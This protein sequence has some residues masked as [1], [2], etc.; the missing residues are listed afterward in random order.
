MSETASFRLEH[1]T[2]IRQEPARV[3][4]LIL[5]VDRWPEIFPSCVA[6]SVLEQ[7]ER[8]MRIELTARI[9]GGTHTARSRRVLSPTGYRIDFEQESPLPP[10]TAVSGSWEVVPE[11]GFGCRVVLIRD[12]TVAGGSDRFATAHDAEQWLRKVLDGSSR[13]EL[14]ALKVASERGRTSVRELM[15]LTRPP[16]T[17]PGHRYDELLRATARRS[18]HRDALRHG[19]ISL[20][21]RALDALTDAVAHVLRDELGVRPGEVVALTACLRPEALITFLAISRVGAV[22]TPINPL[23]GPREIEHQLRDT[24]AVAAVLTGDMYVLAAG[25][26]E[27]L[28]GL[29]RRVGFAGAASGDDALLELAARQPPRPF[30]E[31]E[32]DADAVLSIP[33]SSGTSGLPKGVMLSHRNLVSNALQFVAAHH[34]TE[35]DVLLNGLPVLLSMHLG[36]SMASGATQVLLDRW[37]ARHLMHLAREHEATQLYTVTPMV[38]A[39]TAL[40]DLESLRAPRLRFISSGASSLDVRVARQASTRLGL[41]V[42]QGF[43]LTEASPLT[44]ATPVFAG[45]QGPPGACG[46]PVPDTEQRIVDTAT[47]EQE[48]LPGTVGQLCIRGPQVMRGYWKGEEETRRALRDGWLYTGD[49]VFVD[50]EGFLHY[51]DRLKDVIKHQGHS[52]APAELEA[53][54]K[55]HPAVKDCL[56]VALDVGH[57]EQLPY[58]FVVPRPGA[59][60]PE[61]ILAEVNPRLAGY[62]RIARIEFVN[63][64][65]RSGAGKPLRRLLRE[66]A[67]QSAAS[68]K[69]PSAIPTGA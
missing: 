67:Q 54:L 64:L 33:Y 4:E 2:W 58:A 41:P 53:V 45:Y 13:E 29:R 56:V 8:T 39:L 44:H 69:G 43:G 65:P 55:E 42:L 16:F 31:V 47:G 30:P 23:Y 68:Q 57:D 36:A 51:V 61:R 63:A 49:L 52:I 5:A 34:V 59:P 15:T 6:A 37:D 62:K 25:L 22:V 7:G 10:L 3:F 66:K 26:R 32:V 38:A 11:P 24:E 14:R 9:G 35:A 12:C 28:P 46:L 17:P 48:V 18:P 20:T 50:D 40:E 21:F 19:G 1:S 60:E 27:R